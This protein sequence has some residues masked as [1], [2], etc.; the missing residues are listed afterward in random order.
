MPILT[1]GA[2]EVF[3]NSPEQTRRLGM[4]LGELLAPGD[5]LWL[6]G[7]LG[8]G[9]TTLVQGI[10]AGWGSADNVTSP[11]FVLINV[12][13]RPGRAQLAH[14]DAYR[15]ESADDAEQLDLDF[16]I[17]QGPLIVEWAPRIAAAL[18]AEKLRLAL[19]TVDETRRHILIEPNGERYQEIVLAFKAAVYGNQ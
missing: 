16:Q 12:Y 4:Q 13:R 8:S 17:E 3:S 11:T 10:A 2:T 6:E 18:P 9:K 7:D 1:A 15:L 14:M 19:S 5:V